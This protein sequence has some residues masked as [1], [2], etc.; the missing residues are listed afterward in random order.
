MYI[1]R[2]SGPPKKQ[3]KIEKYRDNKTTNK[4]KQRK[5]RKAQNNKP[6]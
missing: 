1:H 4:R 5:D 3:V 6:P 2:Y